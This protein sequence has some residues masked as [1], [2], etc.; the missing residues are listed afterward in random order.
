MLDFV[1]CVFCANAFYIALALS[2]ALLTM[3]FA[4][5]F[6]HCFYKNHISFLH[7]FLHWLFYIAFILA[8]SSRSLAASSNSRF[9]A[10]AS[11]CFFSSFIMDSRSL[12]G[13]FAPFLRPLS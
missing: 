2:H 9:F 7:R 10:A 1:L 11:I 13:I 3:P 12:F 4:Q 5:P 6:L 8:I